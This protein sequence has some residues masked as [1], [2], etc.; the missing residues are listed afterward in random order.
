MTPVSGNA[1]TI[2]REE[3][4]GDLSCHEAASLL[5]VPPAALERWAQHMAFPH[6]DGAGAAAR[7]AAVTVVAV[8]FLTELYWVV[9]RRVN[10]RR[11]DRRKRRL[12]HPGILQME[13][14]ELDEPWDVGLAGVLDPERLQAADLRTFPQLGGD[15]SPPAKPLQRSLDRVAREPAWVLV[16]VLGTVALAG[17]LPGRWRG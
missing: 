14:P 9:V 3:R 12:P 4:P 6:T 15:G 17:R 7:F 11:A 1:T 13:E 10:A 8:A 5:G 2:A 16:V